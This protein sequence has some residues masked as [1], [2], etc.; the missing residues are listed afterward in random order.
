ME[1]TIPQITNQVTGEYLFFFLLFPFI[2]NPPPQ[3]KKKKKFK[4]VF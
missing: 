3:K 1:V 2:Q 4:F